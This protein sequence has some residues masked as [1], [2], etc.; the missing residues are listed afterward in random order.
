MF[1]GRADDAG[2]RVARSGRRGRAP[3]AEGMLTAAVA[4]VRAAARDS[5]R[6]RAAPRPSV[7]ATRAV[8]QRVCDDRLVHPSAAPASGVAARPPSSLAVMSFPLPVETPPDGDEVHVHLAGP[9]GHSRGTG[10]PPGK[11]ARMTNAARQPSAEVPASRTRPSRIRRAVARALGRRAAAALVLA[12]AVTLPACDRSGARSSPGRAASTWYAG[13][14]SCTGRPAFRIREYRPGLFVLRQPACT[15]YEKPFLYLLVGQS[16]ALLLDTG[17]GGIAVAAPVDSILG[18]WRAAHGGA[19]RELV[20]AHSHG[21]EDHV[22]GDDQFRARPGVTLVAADTDAV[23]AFFGFRAWPTDSAVLDLGGR[24]LDVL[25]I[26]GHE[27]ASLAVH[28]RATGVLLTG[29]TFYPGRL[30]VRDT[31]AFAASVARLT[32]FTASRPISA[33]LGTHIEQARTPFTDYPVGT[34]DQPDEDRLE[35]SRAE[36]M[37]LDSAVRTMRGRF[38][39]A[40]LPRFTIWPL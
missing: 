40:R 11:S 21:H 27:P 13:G 30:Y 12:S 9:R 20:V 32:A 34:H 37:V 36:L 4:A 7:A 39:R 33:I 19:P 24:V 22:A 25:A 8:P 26:P 35:L 15:N 23:R 3:A 28:D 29:D 5:S 6:G 31:A 38:T 16:R 10:I 18:A 1:A 17:A 14:T 2:G